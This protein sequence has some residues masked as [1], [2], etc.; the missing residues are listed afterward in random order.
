MGVR[1]VDAQSVGS[2]ATVTCDHSLCKSL[3]TEQG[4]SFLGL[5][6]LRSNSQCHYAFLVIHASMRAGRGGPA[7]RER[8]LKT[9][10]RGVVGKGAGERQ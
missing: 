9:E 1:G 6:T 7:G 2:L 10:K 3:G 8:C 4:R 5:C